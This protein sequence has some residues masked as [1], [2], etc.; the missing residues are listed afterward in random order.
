MEKLDQLKADVKKNPTPYIL[1]ATATG[2]V[3]GI[4]VTKKFGRKTSNAAVINQWMQEMQAAGFTLY[5]LTPEQS[6]TYIAALNQ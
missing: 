2:L 5:A 3:F 1:A 4:L 6:N